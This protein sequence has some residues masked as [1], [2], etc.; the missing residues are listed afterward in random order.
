MLRLPFTLRQ[1]DIFSTLAATRSFRRC[2][3]ILDISQASVSS[4]IKTL[5]TQLGIE[6]FDREPGRR[7]VLTAEGA[8]FRDDLRAFRS[9]A[10]VLASH[11]RDGETEAE[12][13]K[14]KILVGKGMFDAYVRPKLDQFLAENPDISLSFETR[15]PYGNV[16]TVV[17]KGEYAFAIVNQRFDQPMMPATRQLATVR[18]GIYGHSKFIEGKNLPLSPEE[19]SAL[20]FIMPQ[21]RGSISREIIKTYE[22]HGIRPRRIMGQTEY[23]DVMASMLERGIGIASFSE[24]ILPPAMRRDVVLLHEMHN[25]RLVFY[26]RD[27]GLDHRYDP[28]ERFLITSIVDDP[29]YPALEKGRAAT[30]AA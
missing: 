10:E 3:E 2:A 6:L 4:Q 12:T 19:I 27:H 5:E 26:R 18:G 7:P 24:A 15:L 23:F 14:C 11:R 20:P 13:L 29:A 16:T 8:A 28:V 21:V 17:G 30:G 1:L 25:W 22:S 9:A